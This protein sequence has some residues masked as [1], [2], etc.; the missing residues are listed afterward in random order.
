MPLASSIA[1]S[2]VPYR[3]TVT[4]GPKTSWQETLSSGTGVR[5]H[6]RPDEVAVELAAGEDLGAAGPCL[7]DPLQDPV[8]GV[9]VDHGPDVGLL[10]CRVAERQR[11]DLRQQS[12]DELVVDALLNVDPL[13]RDAALT[14]EGEAVLRS[15]RDGG[16]QVGVGLD[17]QRRRVAELEVDALP[18]R[19][20]AR[21]SSRRRSSR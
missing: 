4:T 8:A 13:D 1:S 3:F 10:V 14:G 16:V 20:L 9:L 7:V 12:G 17:D 18:G 2:S 6:G 19:A 5:D 11:L 15:R 21:A